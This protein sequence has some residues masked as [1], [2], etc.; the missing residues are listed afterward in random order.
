[1]KTKAVDIEKLK[2]VVLAAGEFPAPGGLA[3]KLMENARRVVACDSAAD[4]FFRR[5]SRSPD[6]VVGD[7]DSVRLVHPNVIRFSEQD[8]NDLSKAI[9][10]CR[11]QG[12]DDMVV[13]GAAGLRDDHSL[14]NIFRALDEAVAVVTDYGVFYPVSGEAHFCTRPGAGV[15]VFAPDRGTVMTSKGLEWPLDGV[16]FDNLYVATLNRAPTGEF[17]VAADRPVFVYIEGAGL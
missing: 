5:F 16:K 9:A 10:Y 3:A 4:S 14:G 13:L 7:C 2:T 17:T 6:V 12:W 15:S 8:T 1:M 11:A